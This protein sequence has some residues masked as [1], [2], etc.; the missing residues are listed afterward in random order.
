MD[1]VLFTKWFEL[2]KSAMDEHEILAEN[3]YNMDEKG[4]V[5][6]LIANSKVLISAKAKYKFMQ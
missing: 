1:E 3:T 4:C 2:F 5:M 6:G